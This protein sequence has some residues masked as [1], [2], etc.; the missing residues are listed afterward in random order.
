MQKSESVAEIENHKIPL[1]FDIKTDHLIFD[2]RLDFVFI[3]KKVK[4]KLAIK[5]ILPF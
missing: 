1:D 2:R 3:D 4:K 5:W